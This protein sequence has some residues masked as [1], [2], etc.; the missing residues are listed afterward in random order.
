MINIGLLG[1]G[2]VGQGIVDILKKK[3]DEGIISDQEIRVKKILVRNLDK[4]RQVQVPNNMLT[5]NPNDI[6][7][8]EDINIVIEVTGDLDLSYKL[9]KSAMNKKKHVI[10]ANKALVSAFL[11]ELSH[12]AEENNVYFL[13]E[14]S[15]AGGIPVLKALKDQIRINKISKLQG[16]LNGTCNYILT[17]MSDEFLDYGQVLKEAQS[18][19]YA[20]ADPSSDVEGLD[21]LRKLR[22]LSS[23]AL[24]TSITEEDIVCDGIDKISALDIQLIR[25]KGRV[26]K[27]IGQVVQLHGAYQAIVQPKAIKINDYFA[28]VKDAYNS[29]SFQGDFSGLLNFYG[30]GA[31]M[32]PTANAI[33]TDLVDCIIGTQ[34]MASPLRSRKLENRNKDIKGVYYL[35][36]SNWDH[37][38]YGVLGDLIDEL[39]LDT[40]E[41]LAII[42]K[43]T[44]LFDLL[45]RIAQVDKEYGLVSFDD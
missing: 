41:N 4:E 25:D 5:L 29:V 3:S 31:G 28:G 16:I 14:A 9:L 35:R 15:V 20:E 26:V 24:G 18:L 39:L 42:T 33:L 23:L 45:D 21:T 2:T 40:S 44:S 7:E 13:Y 8:D 43:K 12:I 11:E 19:G 30:P 10:T 17:K 32:H 36:I 1:F 38:D 22:I 6:I 27:L 37:G 34:D